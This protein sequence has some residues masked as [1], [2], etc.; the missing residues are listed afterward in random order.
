[1]TLGMSQ[2]NPVIRNLDP[3]L[4]REKGSKRNG[5]QVIIL[6]AEARNSDDENEGSP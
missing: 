2:T 3:R 6:T 1:V 4:Q 5:E